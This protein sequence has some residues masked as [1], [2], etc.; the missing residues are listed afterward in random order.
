[1]VDFKFPDVGEGIHEGE[2]VKWHVKVG[3]IVKEDQTLVSVE[4]DKAVVE[5][6]SPTSGKITDIRFKDG[7]TVKVGEVICVIGSAGAKVKAVAAVKKAPA[8]KKGKKAA[9]PKK[10]ESVAVVG[11]LEEAP[12]EPTPEI[13][14]EVKKITT[15]KRVKALP[16][17]KK[18]AKDKG[19]DLSTVHGSGPD[20]GITMK[21]ITAYA[22]SGKPSPALEE[23]AKKIGVTLK[24]KYD[25]FGF[26]DRVPMTGIRKAIARKM[27]KS[28]Y[29]APHVWHM[30][31][32]DV[33]KL[34]KL[35]KQEKATAAKRGVKL[36]FMP[37]IIRAL[38]GALKEEPMFNATMDDEAQEI[39]VK[40]YY[41]I[42]IAVDTQYGLMVPNLK[43]VDHKTLLQIGKEIAELAEKARKKK[44]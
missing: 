6:P 22:A 23:H 12:D 36:T 3:D 42:G 15:G 10:R 28:V 35:R 16:K 19:I 43:K 38:I 5:I 44:R 30:D 41:N 39:L 8:G 26:F 14:H 4:T 31:E 20:G 24:R 13:K 9:K 18:Y 40:K 27:T 25:F 1:M 2:I 7:D 29:T 34:W 33:T 21:D 32:A 37:F 17:V 11:E